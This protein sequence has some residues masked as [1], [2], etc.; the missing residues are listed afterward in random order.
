MAEIE[1]NS[2]VTPEGVKHVSG[3]NTEQLECTPTS[4]TVATGCGPS[5]TCDI[6]TGQSRPMGCQNPPQAGQVG[7]VKL[8]NMLRF[9]SPSDNL[10]PCSRK[11]C[12]NSQRKNFIAAKLVLDEADED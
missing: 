9:R 12:K 8:I 3:D 5:S 1:S 10:S 2:V 11:L 7:K 6:G 4:P